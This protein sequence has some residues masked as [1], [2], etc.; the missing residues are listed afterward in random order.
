MGIFV[1]WCYHRL[2]MSYLQRHQQQQQQQKQLEEASQAGQQG[3][4]SPTAERQDAPPLE[5]QLRGHLQEQGERSPSGIQE[6]AAGEQ[7]ANASMRGRT[8]T[9]KSVLTPTSRVRA[10][11]CITVC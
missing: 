5:Q 1:N 11:L 10:L 8:P 2:Y 9:Y 3:K 6:Q 4:Q 7:R